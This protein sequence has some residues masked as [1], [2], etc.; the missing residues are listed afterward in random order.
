MRQLVDE[1]FAC[2][3]PY[4]SPEG[5]PVLLTITIPEIMQRLGGPV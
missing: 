5:R 1:L 2:E 3:N 4:Y